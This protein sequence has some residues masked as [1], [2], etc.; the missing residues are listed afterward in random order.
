LRPVGTADVV[1][2]D[3]KTAGLGGDHGA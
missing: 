1:G 2:S 3:V